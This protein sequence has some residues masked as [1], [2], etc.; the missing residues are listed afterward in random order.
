MCWDR[1]QVQVSVE[2]VIDLDTLRREQDHPC[3]LDGRPVPAAIGREIA[4]YATAFRRMVTD[5]VTGH[6]LDY[7][8]RTYLPAPLRTY[9]LARDTTCRAPGCATRDRRR[10]QL[11]HAVAFPTGPS[12]TANTGALCTTCHQLKTAGHTQITDSRPDGSATWTTAWGQTLTIP[13]RRYLTGSDP[14]PDPPP[15]TGPEP[16]APPEPP[17]Y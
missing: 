5:P 10:L 6:L 8:T 4:G 15:D 1:S 3:L 9:V 12:S 14:D 16:L 11:D 2:V 7:G 13:P 17:P